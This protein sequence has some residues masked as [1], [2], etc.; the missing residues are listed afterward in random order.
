MNHFP[1]PHIRLAHRLPHVRVNQLLPNIVT[2]IS[3][4]AGMVAVRYGLQGKWEHAL[5]AITASGICDTLDGRLARLLKGT[6]H[7]GAELDSLADIVAFGVAPALVMY[8]WGLQDAGPLGWLAV[9]AFP[10]CSALRLARFNTNLDDPNPVPWA[11]QFF[12]GVPTP[13]GAGLCI[14]PLVI[15][16]GLTENG[17]GTLANQHWLLIP[18]Q[19]LVG[20]LMI[21]R[22]PTY[23]FKKMK[24]PRGV[25]P[26]LLMVVVL[27][28]ALFVTIPWIGMGLTLT[29][30]ALTL[31]LASLSWRRRVREAARAAAAP[32]H[33]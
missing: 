15:S 19:L 21:S 31:P 33:S 22:V 9:M 5:F 10:C 3:L 28:A 6:S 1:R 26:L 13:G 27:V 29:A 24:I 14:F 4:C 20:L 23:S 18:W 17:L 2:L 16:L 25:V 12:T 8:L 11:G 32:L 7:F 30:Y